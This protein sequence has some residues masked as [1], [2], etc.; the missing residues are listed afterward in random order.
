MDQRSVGSKGKGR[1][2]RHAEGYFTLKARHECRPTRKV[3]STGV[4]SEQPNVS[5]SLGEVACSG[6]V[7]LTRKT[8]PLRDRSYQSQCGDAGQVPLADFAHARPWAQ[9]SHG[10]VQGAKS[11][12][13]GFGTWT[14]SPPV[15]ILIGLRSG[16]RPITARNTFSS[17]KDIHLYLSQ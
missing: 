12:V 5:L 9:Q 13:F 17:H 4:F 10:K 3:Y 14:C 8:S 16:V 11:D 2:K 6:L 7:L 1:T 15:T